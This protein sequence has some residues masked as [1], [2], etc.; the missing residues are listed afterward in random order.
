[1]ITTFKS[2]SDCKVQIL[3]MR[4]PS[5]SDFLLCLYAQLVGHGINC[6]RD[7]AGKQTGFVTQR[8]DDELMILAMN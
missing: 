3:L 6:P 7:S 2:A 8:E 1:M 5:D 4:I